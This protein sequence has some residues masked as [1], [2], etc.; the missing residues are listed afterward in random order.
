MTDKEKYNSICEKYGNS[1][2]IQMAVSEAFAYK[3]E[4]FQKT[5]KPI[6]DVEDYTDYRRHLI[7]LRPDVAMLIHIFSRNAD[8]NFESIWLDDNDKYYEADHECI[9]DSAHQLIL[10]LEGHWCELFIEALRDEC[11]DI[12]NHYHSELH[13]LKI[14]N[15]NKTE[16]KDEQ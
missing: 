8:N 4:E 15:K 2:E 11:D 6:Y 9:K 7:Q 10:Q 5:H 3:E 16:N 14:S 13:K 1:K 12:L